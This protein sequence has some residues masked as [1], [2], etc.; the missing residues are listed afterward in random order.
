VI[1]DRYA[2]AIF[3]VAQDGNAVEQVD[4]DLTSI[5]E[6][7]KSNQDLN[8]LWMHPVVDAEDKKQMVRQLLAGKVHPLTLNLLQLL[9][10]KKRGML[11][12]QVQKAFHDRYNALRRRATVKVT[13]A[14][15]L[16]QSQ[17]DTLRAQLADKLAK[18]VHMETAVDPSLIGGMI[19]QIEDQVIDNSLR[20]R[21]SALSHSLN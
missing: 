12:A 16:E 17:A 9:F 19:L 1:A 7:L 4:N 15:P 11:F 21:L 10:D 18:D 14:M 3:S 2:E 20:G 6:L 8:R 5:V 13:S